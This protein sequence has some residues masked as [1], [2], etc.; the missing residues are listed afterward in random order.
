MTKNALVIPIRVLLKQKVSSLIKIGGLAIGFSCSLLILLYLHF[1]FSYDTFHSKGQNIYRV[2]EDNIT[3]QG[4]TMV[5]SATGPIGP[6]LASE[7]PEVKG[8]VRFIPA[9]M[10]MKFSDKHFQEDKI[11]FTD[12]TVFDIFTFPLL[13]GDLRS[14]LSNP[15]SIVLTST[16]VQ[17]YFGD[18]NPIGQAL[19][20]DNEILFT[21]TGVIQDIPSNSHLHFDMLLSMSTRESVSPGWL[22]NWNWS[23]YTYL[24]LDPASDPKI[25]EQKL[26]PFIENRRAKTNESAEIKHALSLQSLSEIHLH[27]K[28]KGESSTPGSLS[29]LYVFSVVAAFILLIACV[30]F[31]NLTTA[32]A[33]KRAREIAV[34]KVIGGTRLQLVLQFLGESVIITL[35]AAIVALAVCNLLLPFFRTLIGVPVT[36]D[37]LL[38]PW[39]MLIYF[40]FSLGVGLLAGCY[41]AIVLSGFRPIQ[42]FKGTFKSSSRSGILREGLIVVQFS[43]AIAL[44]VA[45]IT[46]FTQLRY[47]QTKDLGYDKE[48]I[49]VLYFGDDE[50][51]QQRTE[52]LKQE[53]LRT[54]NLLGA[55]ASSHIP[56]KAPGKVRSEMNEVGGAD[57]SLIAVDYD[58]IDFYDIPLVAGRNF[59]RES[60]TDITEGLMVNEA[61]VRQFG[62]EKPEDILGK[63]L[64]QR[65]QHGTVIGVVKN[66][67]YASLHH[68]IDAMVIRM[69][70]KSLSYISLRFNANEI[71]SLVTALEQRWRVLAPNRPFDYFFLDEQFAQ[72]YHTDRQ[73]GQVFATS[74]AISIVLACL[75][76]FGLVTFIVEQRTKEIGIRKVL[77][78]SVANVH[79]LLSRN[80]MKPILIATIIATL[81]SSYAMNLWLQEFPYRIE[82]EAWTFA[83]AGVLAIFISQL[84]LSLKSIRAALANPVDSLRDE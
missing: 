63:Q 76:L 41:P 56:G 15:F 65:G 60:Q 9:T 50:D 59:S 75:G 72:M 69:R 40:G 11:F 47:M 8:A 79:V 35:C 62:F 1:E 20:I 57:V 31:I 77:G 54:P 71:H 30:N 55:S 26:T 10:L 58:F 17:K 39:S 48:G 21:V 43:I 23:A 82:L 29:N 34:R 84:T 38:T 67:H 13:K 7:F 83:L 68:E 6:L 64:L 22:D 33:G 4:T 32:Q 74:A 61:A 70:A 80:F 27:S 66:F 24:E 53:L 52:T 46:V 42:I 16:A 36:A 37:I 19:L 25:F 73:F 81:I 2:V 14:A 5:A 78:A 49:L 45:T 3:P 44:V 28:R 18:A 12:S 51:I